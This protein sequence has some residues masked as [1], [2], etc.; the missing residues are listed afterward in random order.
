[1]LVNFYINESVMAI[2]QDDV[3]K[4]VTARINFEFDFVFAEATS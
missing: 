3:S 2:T 4:D 1:M